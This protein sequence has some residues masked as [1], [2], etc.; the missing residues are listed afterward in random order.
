MSTHAALSSLGYLR[1]FNGGGCHVHTKELPNGWTVSV[2]DGNACEIA[3]DAKRVHV[4]AHR[5][6]DCE[7]FLPGAFVG[8]SAL[9]RSLPAFEQFVACLA[10][11]QS[12]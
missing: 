3:D 9:G 12:P 4:N 1:V 2:C 7:Q 11:D 6:D 8:G 5:T 10:Q